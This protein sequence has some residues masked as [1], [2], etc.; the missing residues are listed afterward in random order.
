M[1]R[2]KAGLAGVRESPPFHINWA[3]GWYLSLARSVFG[4]S[5]NTERKGAA[6]LVPVSAYGFEHSM[7]E[8]IDEEGAWVPIVI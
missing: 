6:V 3:C 8:E 4:S 2:V 5:L 1:I 7:A